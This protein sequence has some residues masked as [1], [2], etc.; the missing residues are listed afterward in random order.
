MINL[1]DEK[2]NNVFIDVNEIK[3]ILPD[4][5][6]AKILLSN[7]L[8]VKVIWGQ[9]QYDRYIQELDEKKIQDACTSYGK[10]V[11]CTGCKHYD[12]LQTS[13]ICYDCARAYKD[14]Y[15]D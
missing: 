11:L 15:E 1:V 2:W 9:Y 14:R 3:A 10:P 7:G 5:K 6:Y 13:A 8:T 4:G 12:I